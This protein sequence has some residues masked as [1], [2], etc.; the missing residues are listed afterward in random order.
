M[1]G[2]RRAGRDSVYVIALLAEKP[3]LPKSLRE[4]IVII[5]VSGI[6][7]VIARRTAA[8]KLS[9]RALRAQHGLIV[10]LARVTA[11]LL[12][13]RFGAFLERREL[14]RLIRSRRAV[15]RKALKTVSGCEQMTLRALNREKL[16]TETG[17]S[18]RTGAD[19][20]RRRA[21]AARVRLPPSV[22]AIRRALDPL[23]KQERI[24]RG[25]GDRFISINHLIARG[26]ATRYRSIVRA[27]DKA[28]AG[29]ALTISG[30]WPPFAFTPDIW[31]TDDGPD[32]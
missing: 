14:D 5:D 1:T 9:E 21:A 15:L 23:V 2:R 11:A 12:P 8:P 30:P 20:L 18:A 6:Q 4:R 24:D 13:V 29:S 31:Q 10:R 22:T 28:A 3:R 32:A 25:P 7:V 27:L 19:Y 16:P 26:T 17:E